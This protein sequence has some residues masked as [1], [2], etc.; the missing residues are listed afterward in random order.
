MICHGKLSLTGGA[1]IGQDLIVQGLVECGKGLSAGGTI[2]GS[3][4]IRVGRGILAGG[5]INGGMH[6]E[7]G[8]GIKSGESIQ[9]MDPSR[10]ARACLQVMKSARARAMGSMPD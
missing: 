8:W 2:V 10:P 4:S 6:L 3:D 7:A 5:A 9:R 1:F